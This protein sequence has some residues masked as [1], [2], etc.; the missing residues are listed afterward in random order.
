MAGEQHEHRLRDGFLGRSVG[1]DRRP[2]GGEANRQVND[3]KGHDAGRGDGNGVHLRHFD[4][5]PHR[6]RD[7]GRRVAF[8]W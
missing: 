2:R 7:F 8:R 5:G 1:D 3:V 4:V 6:D